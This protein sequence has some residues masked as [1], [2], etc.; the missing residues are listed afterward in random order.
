MITFLKILCLIFA[1]WTA[2]SLIICVFGSR[3]AE[4]ITYYLCRPLLIFSTSMFL[5]VILWVLFII[6]AVY[7][8]NWGLTLFI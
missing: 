2:I 7:A 8:M 3:S 4:D 5:G 1:L 6:G